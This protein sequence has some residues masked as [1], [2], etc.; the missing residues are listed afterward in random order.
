MSFRIFFYIFGTFIFLLFTF[1]Y[2]KENNN[3]TTEEEHIEGKDEENINEENNIEDINGLNNDKINNEE[4]ILSKE[5]KT[6]NKK[7]NIK[8]IIK[9]FRFWRLSFIHFF[10]SFFFS[11][12]MGTSR[13]FG[14]II[15]IEGNALQLLSLCQSGATIIL[16]PILGILIDKKGPLFFLRIAA[17]ISMIPGILLT[18]FV[19]NTI[20]FISSFVIAI[21]GLVSIFTCFTPFVMEIYGIQESVIIGGVMNVFAKLSEITTTVV[22]F[23]I[24]LFYSNDEIIRPYQIM[25]SIGSGFCLLSF[26][27]LILETNKKYEY[28]QEEDLGDLV[29]KAKYGEI[30]V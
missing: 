29:E 14:A 6:M 30:G 4:K 20:I 16:G 11:F 15:G 22:A 3:L 2:R 12:I 13:T 26:I 17:I 9:T 10:L 21:L 8:N 25:Y 23:V 18:F 7:K 5:I 19:K 28:D 1:E 27:L 24:S